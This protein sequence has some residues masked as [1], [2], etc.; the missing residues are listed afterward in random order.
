MVKKQSVKLGFSLIEL[1]IVILIVGILISGVTQ[2]S[3]LVKES[4][5]KSAL[6]VT[7]SSDVASIP[8]LA[9][10]LDTTD[11]QNLKTSTVANIATS[12]YGDLS[13]NDPISAWNDRNPQTLSKITVTA[14]G[15]S[16]RPTYVGNGINGLPSISFIKASSQRLSST[17]SPIINGNDNYTL[18]AVFKPTSLSG[19]SYVVAQS[20]TTVTNGSQGAIFF[21]GTSGTCC[22]AGF[23]NDYIPVAITTNTN[24]IVVARVNNTQANNITLY[25]NGAQSSA[26]STDPSTLDIGAEVITVGARTPGTSHFQ[27]LISEI[28][29]YNRSLKTNEINSINSYLAKKYAIAIN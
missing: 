17:T 26:P 14:P 19:N 10:W 9:F 20:I 8:D 28:I 2:G 18:I 1:S 15:D 22:F 29:I 23:N 6:A 7:N 11:I 21:T 25:I 5:L 4:K 24:Y 27:G 12:G 3:R 13:D 16:N